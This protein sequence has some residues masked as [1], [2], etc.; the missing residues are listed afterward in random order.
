VTPSLFF[1][2]L[3]NFSMKKT[4]IALAAVAVSS[5]A[6][7]QVT[8][9]GAVAGQNN[10]VGTAKAVTS[11]AVSEL[12]FRANEDIGGGLKA[13]AFFT[14]ENMNNRGTD[15]GSSPNGP[16]NA[17][18][19]ISLGGGFGTVAVTNTRSSNLAV[20]GNVFGTSISNDFYAIVASRPN[21]QVL[22]YTSP[23]LIP[24]LNVSLA[25]ANVGNT[26]ASQAAKITVV[27][28][29]Y[30]AGPLALGVQQKSF[31]AAGTPAGAE[32]GQTEGF[33]RYNAGVAVI[34]LGYGSKTTTAG[35]AVTSY[36]VSVPMGAITLGLEGATRGDAE[37]MNYGVRYALSKRTTLHVSGG[38]FQTTAANSQKQSRVR[39]G[40]S[41]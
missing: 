37:F 20:N 26:A 2:T 13:S 40:H 14:I 15:A 6:M 36:G 29:S 34:G 5:A 12:T 18:S 38:E 11:V 24:G 28:A 32:D 19:G 4:L 9:S 10:K 27:G 3:E 17:D 21:V 8:I 23:A 39:I 41:F 33:V 25:Q 16:T 1:S 31:N 30:A 35:K 7:A 22:S